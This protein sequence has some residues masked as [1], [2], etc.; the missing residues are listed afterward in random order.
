MKQIIL[1]FLVL[2]VPFTFQYAKTVTLPGLDN[3][4]QIAVDKDSLY[5]VDNTTVYIYSLKDFSQKFKFGRQGEGPGEFKRYAG[6]TIQADQILVNSMA[7]LSF[8]DKN[9]K[10]IREQNAATNTLGGF[11]PMDKL[12][13]ST[14]FLKEDKRMFYTLNLYDENLVKG[15]L[16]CRLSR[17]EQA[18]GMKINALDWGFPKYQV[19]KNNVYCE[20]LDKEIYGFDVSGKKILTLIPK[21]EKLP[22]SS[23][24]K[25]RFFKT[26]ELRNKEEFVRVKPRL[27][28]PSHFPTIRDFRVTND[29]V[30]IVTFKIVDDAVEILVYDLQGKFLEKT[31]FPGIEQNPFSL[32]PFFIKG[33]KLYRLRD[34]EETE[35]W[36]LFISGL[37][38]K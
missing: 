10:F 34:N 30:Y 28:F 22:V 11:L 24:Y 1:F 8:F 20:E 29:K 37:S 9:G 31:F 12:Y 26:L 16:I 17:N 23:A 19:Y 15:K 6:I 4:H 33:D 25:N 3:P 5:I 35:E 36:E 38:S 13:I 2:C 18:S 21:D 32:H 7:R 14:S 27:Q